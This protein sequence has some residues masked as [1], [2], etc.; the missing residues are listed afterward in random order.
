MR[1]HALFDHISSSH[2][3]SDS[4]L[5]HHSVAL[6]RLEDLLEPAHTE[7]RLN[8]GSNF[9][10]IIDSSSNYETLQA[11]LD[12]FRRDVEA[13]ILLVLDS[14]L[15]NIKAS[16]LVTSHVT[17]NSSLDIPSGSL[18]DRL[19]GHGEGIVDDTL[20]ECHA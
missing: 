4:S 2:V 5:E 3:A 9:M 6:D 8:P 15:D 12:L 7:V 19:F 20:L 16:F 10:D 11:L 13:Q 14:C 18:V 17:S 1:P